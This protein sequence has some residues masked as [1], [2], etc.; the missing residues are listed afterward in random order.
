MLAN[1]V[2][3]R[4]MYIYSHLPFLLQPSGADVSPLLKEK[5]VTVVTKHIRPISLTPALSKLAEDFIVSNY[6][7]PVVLEL[8]DPKQ[9]GAI[10]KSSTLQAL[11]S[12]VHSCTQTTDGTGSAVRVVLLDYRKAFDLVD[13]KILADKILAD[14][15]Y[16]VGLPAR[17]AIFFLTGVSES[18]FQAIASQNGCQ[19]HLVS[20]KELN[21]A[22]GSL[23]LRSMISILPDLMHG[24]T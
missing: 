1:Q 7:G 16:H 17:C 10:P 12:M 18:S 19:F 6:D 22:L 2:F 15:A 4:L 20:L 23:F 3:W 21:L 11:I 8:I 9:F 14:C 24:S 13:H 5:P